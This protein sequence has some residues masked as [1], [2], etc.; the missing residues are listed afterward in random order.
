[1]PSARAPLASAGTPAASRLDGAGLYARYC[2]ACHGSEGR[3]DGPNAL[4]LPVRPAVHRD[5]ELMSTRTNDRLFDAVYSGGYPLGKSVAMPGFGE[6]LSRDE[7]WSI[8]RYL[9]T[10]CRCRPPAWSTDGEREP[11]ER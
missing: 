7:I 10:L 4:F 5:A 6:T 1:M 11:G 3:G 8:V 9:R 2:V